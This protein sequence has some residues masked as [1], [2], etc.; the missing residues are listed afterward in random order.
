M[1]SLRL[2]AYLDLAAR[3]KEISRRQSEAIQD[4]QA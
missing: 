1:R 2:L 3:L 4:A